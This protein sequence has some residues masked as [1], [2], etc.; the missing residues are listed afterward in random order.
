MR[1][2]ICGYIRIRFKA[3]LKPSVMRFERFF[4]SYSFNRL[5]VIR[6]QMRKITIDISK[7]DATLYAIFAGLISYFRNR[8]REG[9][10][11]EVQRRCIDV[12]I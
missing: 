7:N 12:Q 8:L 11:N 5:I 1:L 9:Y 4:S 6:S 2:R 3:T 10:L